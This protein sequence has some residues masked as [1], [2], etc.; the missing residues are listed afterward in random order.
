FVIAKA[1]VG[2]LRSAD[3]VTIVAMGHGGA[4]EADEDV[5]CARYL[6]ALVDGG[7]PAMP[8]IRLERDHSAEGWPAWFPRRDGELAWEVDRF[9]FALPVSREHGLLIARPVR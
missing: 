9:D 8:A 4:E 3:D 2:Y 7:R 6:A 1:T 5:A